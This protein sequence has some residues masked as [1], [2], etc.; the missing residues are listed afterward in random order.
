[1]GR[2]TGSALN[3]VA[4]PFIYVETSLSTVLDLHREGLPAIW[5]D[6]GS[7]EVLDA[8]GIARA[9]LLVIA[10]P[11]V[12]AAFVAAEH[13]RTIRPGISIVARA[14][15]DS[16]LALLRRASADA[17]VLP[18]VEGAIAMIRDSL[19]LLAI[20]PQT[21]ESE[22]AALSE[23]QYRAHEEQRSAD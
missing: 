13:A 17:V 11:D 9:R 12:A 2:L 1:V 16:D 23:D 5:G 10:V 3:D 6:V 21:S 14:H 20:E 22:L 7:T 8:A 15:S 18:E 4:V 19:R